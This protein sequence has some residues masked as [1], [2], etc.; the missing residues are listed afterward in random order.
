M[1]IPASTAG[2]PLTESLWDKAF[3]GLNKDL[4][5]SL[6]HTK[7]CK[8][9]ILAA[10]VKAA[11]DK[12]EKCLREHWKFKKP[13]GDVVIVRD[14]LEKIAKWVDRF[15]EVGDTAVQ[16][17]ATYASL[18]WAAVRF[19]LQATVNDIELY[20]AMT[21]GLEIISRLITRYKEFELLYLSRKSSI[22]PVLQ[23]VLTSLYAEVLIYLARTVDFFS[24]K[25]F[26]KCSYGMNLELNLC[27]IDINMQC[28]W[29]RHLSE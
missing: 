11:E 6:G 27:Y 23:E 8:R 15:K 3:D 7:T 10:V 2:Q 28:D 20:G 4:K 9:D 18:P 14:V 24:E 1:I 22:Q 29:Q 25:T 19:L 13:G 17:D 5:A 21:I 26:S 12:K 16:F